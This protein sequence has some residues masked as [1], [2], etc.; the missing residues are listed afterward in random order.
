[1]T[2]TAALVRRD[3]RSPLLV[4][5]VLAP[6][7]LLLAFRDPYQGGYPLCP[8]LLI[9]G[10]PCAT[11]GGLRTVHDLA[12]LDLGAA[13]AMNPMLTVM[14]PMLAVGWVVSLVRAA[15][16]RRAWNPPTWFWIVLGG[17][18]VAFTVARN[19]PALTGYLGPI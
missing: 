6:A 19:I 5:A 12:H 10:F 9:T 11:C 2:A 13:W 8:I 18:I 4:G 16:G 3:V 14:L 7:T 1:M 17:I 15:T